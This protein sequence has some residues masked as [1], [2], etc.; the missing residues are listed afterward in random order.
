[1]LR[2]GEFER[3]EN[4]GEGRM[5]NSGVCGE[6]W[7]GEEEIKTEKVKRRRDER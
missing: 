2:G 6:G 5:R 3:V 4:K 1:M 7:A